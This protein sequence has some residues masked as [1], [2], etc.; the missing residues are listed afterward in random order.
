MV[1]PYRRIIYMTD[2]GRL[3]SRKHIKMSQFVLDSHIG[4]GHGCSIQAH[5]RRTVPQLSYRLLDIYLPNMAEG[6]LREKFD[7]KTR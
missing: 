4:S 7:Y 1:E 3:P 2:S 6:L 5:E